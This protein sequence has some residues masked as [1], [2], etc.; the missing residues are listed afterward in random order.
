MY[1]EGGYP[2]RCGRGVGPRESGTLEQQLPS[3]RFNFNSCDIVILIGG[4]NFESIAVT[5][6][7]GARVRCMSGRAQAR[8]GDVSEVLIG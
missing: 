2:G 4:Y 7:W 8:V 3:W 6:Y 1:E 5:H